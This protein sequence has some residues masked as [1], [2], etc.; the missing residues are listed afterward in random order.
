MQRDPLARWLPSGS[1]HPG[2]NGRGIQGTIAV[3]FA[4][5]VIETEDSMRHVR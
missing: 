4:L 3:K 1:Q 2:G 5:V